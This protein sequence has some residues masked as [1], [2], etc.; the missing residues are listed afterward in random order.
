MRVPALLRLPVDDY[1]AGLEVLLRA[2][3]RATPLAAAAAA[4][5]A[6]WLYLPAHEL[7]HAL[8]CLA[9]GGTVTRLEIDAMYGAAWLQ[10][11]FPFVAVG[12][13]YAG[14]LTGFDTR[15][16][17]LTYLLT[18]AL[19]Y[20]LTILI[21]VPA[22][23]AAAR[24]PA[25]WGQALLFGAALP[26]A[27][28]PFISLAGDY[29]E[30]GSIIVSR[31]VATVRPGFDPARWRGDDLALLVERLGTLDPG[32]LDMAGVAASTLLGTALAFLT[33]AAGVWVAGGRRPRGA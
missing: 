18:D 7:L 19:P 8:G 30:I 16:S 9:G 24:R 2:P 22:L 28:A 15:G 3:S 14:Q 20:A 25:G 21:G 33:Y 31:L 17:D 5:A 4:V 13:R 11:V 26:V 10:R 32:R 6:W 1:L 23:R 27:L 29:Y 12:S